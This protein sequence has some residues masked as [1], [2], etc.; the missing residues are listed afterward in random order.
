MKNT[1]HV[2]INTAKFLPAA[3]GDLIDSIES[4][5]LVH[6]NCSGVVL[7]SH[8]YPD[9]RSLY[10]LLQG[11]TVVEVIITRP[12]VWLRGQQGECDVTS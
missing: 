8:M 10:H 11:T 12:Q 2:W 3:D 4:V 9:L 5:S 6:A 1:T 7:S